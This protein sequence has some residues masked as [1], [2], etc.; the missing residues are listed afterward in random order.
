MY[1]GFYPYPGWVP[2]WGPPIGME[3]PM[4]GGWYPYGGMAT[5]PFYPQPTSY[6]AS[7]FATPMPKEHE[8]KFLQD[9]ANI[10]KEQLDWIELRIKELEK[11]K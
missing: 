1:S 4:W 9:Q 8:I 10:L 7:P 5:M 11:S 3:Y 6:P 2:P